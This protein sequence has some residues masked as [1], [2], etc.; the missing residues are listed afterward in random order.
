MTRRRASYT[1]FSVWTFFLFYFIF[2]MTGHKRE[3]KKIALVPKL[4]RPCS[5][6]EDKRTSGNGGREDGAKRAFTQ[7]LC[8]KAGLW[9]LQCC[10]AGLVGKG[11]T[12]QYVPPPPS[13]THLLPINNGHLTLGEALIP[14][15]PCQT[16][17]GILVRDR[18]ESRVWK[19]FSHSHLCV[20]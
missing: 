12:V 16:T 4:R 15:Q 8:Y 17:A 19:A 11:A 1:H 14:R 6:L 13:L 20:L 18:K 9:L 2:Y 3:R 7:R 10:P 5:G